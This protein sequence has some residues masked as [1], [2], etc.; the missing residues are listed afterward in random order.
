MLFS[1]KKTPNHKPKRQLGA[2]GC[3][4]LQAPHPAAPSSAGAGARRCHRPG[5]APPLPPAPCESSWPTPL[6][7]LQGRPSGVASHFTW[8]YF[9]V[10]GV[11]S[12]FPPGE[13]DTGAAVAES[14]R[15]EPGTAEPS[16]PS[17]PL[18]ARGPTSRR[19]RESPPLPA[20]SRGREALER[21]AAS[22]PFLLLP[23]LIPAEP[24]T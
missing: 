22:S 23:R 1:R 4:P 10:A 9:R 7:P 18:A 15:A 24:A 21:A 14:R 5:S 8:R 20:G 2:P 19:G 11:A 17:R 13:K 16:R 6:L 3:A 12:S